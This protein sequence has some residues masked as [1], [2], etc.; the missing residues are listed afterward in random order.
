MSAFSKLPVLLLGIPAIVIQAEV[1]QAYS[2]QEIHQ[3][4]REISVTIDGQNPGSGFIVAR[5]GNT[6]WVLTAKHVVATEDEYYIIA[7]DGDEHLLDYRT[8][9]KLPGVDLALLRFTSDRPY[10]VAT[11]G[12]YAADELNRPVFTYGWVTRDRQTRL[13]AGQVIGR[14]FALGVTRNPVDRGYKLFYTNVTEKGMSGGPVLD[15]EGRVVGVHGQADGQELYDED[16]GGLVRVKLGF[17]AGIPTAKMLQVADR[18]GIALNWQVT[19]TTP[20]PIGFEEQL[21]IEPFL[22]VAPPPDSQNAVDWSNWGNHLYRTRQFSRAL[23]AFERAIRLKRN[24]YPAWYQRGNVLYALNDPWGAIGAFDRTVQIEPEFYWAWRD[25]GA[26]L[27]TLG[28][29]E[30]ALISFDRALEIKPDDHVIWYMRG[31]LLTQELRRYQDALDSY[32]RALEVNADFAPAW[33]GRAKALYELGEPET[34]LTALDEAVRLDGELVPAWI[35]RGLVLASLDRY[36][37]AIESL[38]A[39]QRLR[40]G[41]PQVRRLLDELGR[42][43]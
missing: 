26:L 13:T 27:S 7:P 34:A 15:S 33:M 28:D 35:L 29:I 3:I 36:P 39:A 17:S 20:R 24:F 22:A 16:L 41:D 21:S 40:P 37:E 18:E 6:Y 25:R 42:F 43:F 5:E 14:D 1:A 8:V 32:D 12:N 9:E 11:L 23:E 2:A 31:N 30:G 4:A 19:A 38:E 10:R